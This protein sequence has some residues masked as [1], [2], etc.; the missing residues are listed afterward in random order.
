MQHQCKPALA[1][2]EQKLRLPCKRDARPMQTRCKTH[3]INIAWELCPVVEVTSF[4]PGFAAALATTV[5]SRSVAIST[6]FRPQLERA[7][8]VQSWTAGGFPGIPGKSWEIMVRP[9]AS[10]SVA[11]WPSEGYRGSSTAQNAHR[12]CGKWQECHCTESLDCG[13]CRQWSRT[14][15]KWETR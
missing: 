8:S 4:G 13:N 15:G 1:P 7:V 2:P 11:S 12:G 10:I 5:C 6:V 14:L 3:D 9:N